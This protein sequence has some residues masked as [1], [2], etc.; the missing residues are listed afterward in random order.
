MYNDIETCGLRSKWRILIYGVLLASSGLFFGYM[1]GIF[2]TFGNIFLESVYFIKD[3]KLKEE[4]LGN[5]NMLCL[6][7]GLVSTLTASLIYERI[8]RYRSLVFLSAGKIFVFVMFMYKSLTMLYFGRFIGGYLACFSISFIPLFIKENLPS[9]YAGSIATSFSIFIATGILLSFCFGTPLAAEYWRFVLSG[10]IIL[11][12][13]ILFVYLLIFKMESPKTIFDKSDYITKD[14]YENY[15]QIY[16]PEGAK[17]E[18]SNFEAEMNRVNKNHSKIKITDLLKNEYR[19]QFSIGLL[20]NLLNQTTGIN[21]LI[22]YSKSIFERLKLPNVDTLTFFMGFVNLL[23]T[24]FLTYFGTT[25]GKRKCLIFGIGMQSASYLILLIG[26]TLDNGF[27]VVLGAY[28]FMF[29]FSMSLGGMIFVYIADI[30]PSI[31]ISFASV[32]QWICSC[33]IGKYALFITN[34]IGEFNVFYIFMV[35]SFAGCVIFTGYSIETE[36]KSGSQI[37]EEFME[38]K[39]LD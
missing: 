12:I 35:I 4:I 19:L 37:K 23:G 1:M 29:S 34:W 24:I 8:G 28:S 5:L 20:L 27:L 6:F 2:N 36:G 9:K 32:S 38:K 25:I 13:P 15:L 11:E 30:V 7:G 39:F 16:T 31:G 21:F 17:E 33:L 14:L 18:T 26:M 3:K 10:P 22:F